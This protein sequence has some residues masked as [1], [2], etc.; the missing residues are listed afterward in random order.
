MLTGRVATVGR[1]ARIGG[2]G[3]Y[4]VLG[5]SNQ[6]GRLPQWGTFVQDSWR[7]RANLTVN[8]G[9]RYDVQMPF[10]SLNDSYSMATLGAWGDQLTEVLRTG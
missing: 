4:S 1:E 9:L 8:A 5:A 2:D 3:N 6:Y 10:Y 7:W